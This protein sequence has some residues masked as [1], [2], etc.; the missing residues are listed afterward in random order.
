MVTSCDTSFLFAIYGNDTHSAR[1]IAWIR[2]QTS[3]ISLS[4]LN[5]Y[6]LMNALR[7]AEYRG[8]LR[9]GTAATCW[10]DFE[11]DLAAG[12]LTTAPCNLATVVAEAK[13]LSASHTLSSGHRSFDILHVASALHLGAKRFLTFDRN[14]RVLARAERLGVPL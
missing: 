14:Q 12:R 4:I 8:A 6:E 1:A 7:F 5:E 9:P 13:R 3:P 2:K 11:A 10:A